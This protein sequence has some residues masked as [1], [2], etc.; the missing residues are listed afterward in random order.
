MLKYANLA[1]LLLFPLAWAA[2]L[3]RAGL[4]PF[5]GLEEISV[6]SGLQTLWRT[7][8]FLAL[9]VSFLALFA[10]YLKV[11]GVALIQFDLAAPRLLPALNILGKL[12]MADIF[13]IAIYIVVAKGVGVGRLETAWGLYL[14]TG[15]VAAS[16]AISHLE[17]KKAPRG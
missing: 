9:L 14:F 6:L 10:P 17:M 12:A 4:L 13:L 3:L 8:V 7:D 11:I 15:C 1:L 16:F 2:P 5:F